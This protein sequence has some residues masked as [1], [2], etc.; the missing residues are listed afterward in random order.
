MA[1]V[2]VDRQIK[3]FKDLNLSF[4]RHPITSDVTVKTDI[5]AVKFAVKNLLM[6][7]RYEFLFHPEIGSSLSDLLFENYTVVTQ[8]IVG[9]EIE[10]TLANYE[11]RAQLV[12]V[13]FEAAPMLNSISVSIT[14]KMVNV[15]E[16]I[17]LEIVL[18]RSR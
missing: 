2:T 13:I 4:T 11:P 12:N 6:T 18:E 9:Q 3:R 16:P 14:F 17:T 1:I 15:S 5:E 10:N 8:N 7:R